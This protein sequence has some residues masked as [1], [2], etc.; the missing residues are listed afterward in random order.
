MPRIFKNPG[1]IAFIGIIK[2][3]KE[4]SSSWIDFPYDL[5][6]TYGVGN[7]VPYIATFDDSVIYRGS[8][9]KMG[10][11]CAMILLRKD[12]FSQIGKKTGE[13]VSVVLTLDD[14]P[15]EL[16]VPKDLHSLLR[17]SNLW[18]AFSNL[19]FTHRKEYVNWIESAKKNETRQT[20]L[21]TVVTLLKS[22]RNTPYE[23]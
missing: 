20:R 11:D 22:K 8:L 5:K 19:S 6:E 10:S 1:P 16:T 21:R 18:D 13:K 23:T 12:V 9:A 14:K 3:N 2:T 15:R 17:D 4:N 7:L